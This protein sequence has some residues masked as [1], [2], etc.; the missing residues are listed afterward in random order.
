[1]AADKEKRK[2]LLQRLGAA[3]LVVLVALGVWYLVRYET[4]RSRDAQALARILEIQTILASYVARHGAYPSMGQESRILGDPQTECLSADGFVPVNS[5]SCR[6]RTFGFFGPL[7][8]MGES[9]I[10][11]YTSLA[12]DTDSACTDKNGCP[13]YKIEFIF[14]TN[15]IASKG[16][17]FISPDGL[18]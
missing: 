16:A 14:E 11:T 12:S 6:E 15:S 9:Q 8:G 13:S 4:A 3:V 2:K 17:H 18:H 5:D 7:P 10:A 1:M